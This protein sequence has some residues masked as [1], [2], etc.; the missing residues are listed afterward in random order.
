MQGAATETLISCWTIPNWCSL[1]PQAVS[2][3][4]EVELPLAAYAVTVLLGST[5]L[6]CLVSIH[7]SC[8]LGRGR[9]SSSVFLRRINF[10]FNQGTIHTYPQTTKFTDGTSLYFPPALPN[11]RKDVS[12]SLLGNT[13]KFQQ[14]YMMEHCFL[15]SVIHQR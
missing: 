14:G 15:A 2:L 8:C 13:Q 3:L 6:K 5:V 11:K 10:L 1:C 7:E 12:L 4:P 9:K